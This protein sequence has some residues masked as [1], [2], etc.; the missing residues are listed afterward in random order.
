[1]A[2]DKLQSLSDEEL[3]RLARDGREDSFETLVFRY[4]GRL[5]RLLG[6]WTGNAHDAED[7]TQAAFVAAYRGLPRY[8][9]GRPFAPWLF[10]IA[11][12]LAISHARAARPSEALSDE[13]PAAEDPRGAVMGADGESRVW[14]TARALLTEAVF[15]ALWLRLAEG[16]TVREIAQVMGKTTVHVKVM[17]H[18]G[19]RVLA[20]KILQDRA[21]EVRGAAP[22]GETI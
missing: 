18:R 8:D 14:E 4:E 13:L 9:P 10:T 7:L 12:R 16:L 3:A 15:T 20:E 5:V 2:D 22:A 17:L 1:M 21:S 19:R 11:R 6:R